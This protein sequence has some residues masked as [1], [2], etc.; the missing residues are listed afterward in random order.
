MQKIL[1]PQ[2]MEL[3]L[4]NIAVKYLVKDCN[5]IPFDILK[6]SAS[7]MALTPYYFVKIGLKKLIKGKKAL[8]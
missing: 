6:S 2:C 5:G 7:I 8:K 3:Y 4:S 1:L